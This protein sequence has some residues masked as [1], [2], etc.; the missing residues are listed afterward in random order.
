MTVFAAV[1]NLTD[2]RYCSFGLDNAQY[3]MP[4]FYY[5]CR[6]NVQGRTVL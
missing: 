4:N 2:T 3:G 6:K 5:P 1:E